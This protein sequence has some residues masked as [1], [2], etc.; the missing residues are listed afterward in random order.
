MKKLV[1]DMTLEERL[2]FLDT[3]PRCRL[4]GS[5]AGDPRHYGSHAMCHVQFER[6]G[7]EAVKG[8]PDACETCVGVGRIPKS[9]V[10][11]INPNQRAI[12]AWAPKCTDCNGTGTKQR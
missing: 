4:C 6:G 1:K 2:A 5:N 12:D 11:P 8:F 9:W 3:K 10:G 7:K